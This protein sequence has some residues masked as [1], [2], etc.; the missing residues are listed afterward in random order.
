MWNHLNVSR[1]EN[2][3][4]LS[5]DCP[6]NDPLKQIIN[7][8]KDLKVLTLKRCECNE[9]TME[10]I[11]NSFEKFG[12]MEVVS[13]ECDID[14]IPDMISYIERGLLISKNNNRKSLK[15]SIDMLNSMI[16]NYTFQG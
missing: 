10:T 15:I 5:I 6:N 13:L 7:S 9:K 3:K 8:V 1:C 2:L 4:T 11:I 16:L 12:N 14:D